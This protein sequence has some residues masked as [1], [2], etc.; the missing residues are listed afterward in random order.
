MDHKAALSQLPPDLAAALTERSDAR[1]LMHLAGHL[2]V[3]VVTGVAIALEVP[4]WWLILLPHG[5]LL[6]FLFT[7]EHEATHQTPFRSRWL[8][9]AVGHVTG[10][11]LLLP[12]TWFRYFHLAHHRHTNDPDLDPELE[13]GGHPET[14]PQYLRHVSGW[15]YWLGM[16]AVLWRSA[17]GRTE[18]RYLP[19]RVKPRVRREARV[20]L[21]LYALVCG[22]L[23]VTDLVLWLWIVPLV[24][25]QPVLRLYLLAE[26]A[27]CAQVADMLANTRTTLTG[28]LARFIAWN[29][30]YHAEHHAMPSVPFHQ[31]PRL[32]E[33]LAPHLKETVAGYRAF[34][35]DY[36]ARLGR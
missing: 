29:M 19:E 34:T 3:L 2:G 6:V 26:H 7:L 36:V 33:R 18:A 4:F 32:H 11:L 25:G 15:G 16:A 10:A 17:M 30:P 24:L 12:F 5:V 14:W 9:E 21:G 8:N 35:R 13:G 31:L 20:L 22:S 23:A 27:R 28:R 1:G